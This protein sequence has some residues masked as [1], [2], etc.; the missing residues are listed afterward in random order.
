MQGDRPERDLPVSPK[1]EIVQPVTF[2]GPTTGVTFCGPHIE[3]AKQYPLEPVS[4]G[5]GQ[6]AYETMKRQ[7]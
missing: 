2:H 7:L 5:F 3:I 1:A 6:V 4:F